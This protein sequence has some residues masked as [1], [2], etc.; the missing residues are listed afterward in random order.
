MSANILMLDVATLKAR[1]AIHDNIDEKLIYPEIKAAQDLYILP[2]VGT[3][4][5]NKLLADINASSL[6]V[7][8]KLLVDSYLLD[9]LIWYTMM[10]LSTSLNYQFWNKG[11]SSATS[12]NTT[13]PTMGE[14]FDVSNKYK[15]RAEGYQKKTILYL[16]QNVNLF[17]E[18]LN[19]GSGIDTV[20]PDRMAYSSPIYLGD[21]CKGR[22][23]SFEE[24][25]QGN[26]FRDCGDCN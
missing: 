16:K 8:Y 18:Y 17:P 1:T 3:A 12:D 14:L 24:K 4:L 21:D 7:N 5:Y 20:I 25:Y 26:I 19:P 11:V 23:R 10:E 2:I 22:R 6:S 13:N 9:T 15:N